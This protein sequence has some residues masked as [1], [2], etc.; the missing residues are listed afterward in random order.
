MNTLY[1][2]YLQ[3]RRAMT[4]PLD[5]ENGFA[6]DDARKSAETHESEKIP[7]DERDGQDNGREVSRKAYGPTPSKLKSNSE[8]TAPFPFD[9]CHPIV[10]IPEL[11]YQ[12]K[13]FIPTLQMLIL[14]SIGECIDLQK[15]KKR[16]FSITQ[17]SARF[18][19]NKR[20]RRFSVSSDDDAETTSDS[21]G[22]VFS[23]LKRSTAVVYERQRWIGRIIKERGV[24]QWRGKPRKQYLVQ[25]EL[26]WVDAS[27]L[28]E[29]Q[30]LANWSTQ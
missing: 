20:V 16:S 1:S 8:S 26:S 28:T 15:R 13:T 29:S 19:H 17:Q 6:Y 4:D 5:H 18:G 7:C 12:M 14:G 11:S 21:E 27:Q 22:S 24:R 3:V 30:L 9:E 10:T 23:P 25:W 2:I